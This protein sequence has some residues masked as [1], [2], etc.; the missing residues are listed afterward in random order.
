[1]SHLDSPERRAREKVLEGV[2]QPEL[3]VKYFDPLILEVLLDPK[4]YQIQSKYLSI[5]FWDISGFSDLCNRFTDNPIMIIWFLRKYFN[6]ANE[7]IHKYNGIL[8]KFIGDGIMAY[9]GYFNNSEVS[10]ANDAVNAALE[11]RKR[12]VKVKDDWISEFNL[13]TSDSTIKLKCGIHSGSL[14]FGILE[15][16]YRNQITVTGPTVN[17]ASRL[18]GKGKDDQILISDDTKKLT[19][20]TFLSH[21]IMVDDIKSW[22]E[23]KVHIVTGKRFE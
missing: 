15:T 18:E 1:M 4:K 19:Q 14:L 22:G 8:D 12:F 13:P 6:E 20:N 11:L 17:F 21:E 16:E 3:L 9:F 5:V 23:V 10:G 7:I 2:E